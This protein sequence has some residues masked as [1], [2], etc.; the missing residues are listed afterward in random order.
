VVPFANNDNPTRGDR[1]DSCWLREARGRASAI[2]KRATATACDRS[3]DSHG[4]DV[5]DAMIVEVGHD[6]LATGRDHGDS[7]RVLEARSCACTVGKRV[8]ATARKRC[9]NTKWRQEPDAVVAE[10]SHDDIVARGDHRNSDRGPE[11]CGRAC[12]VSKRSASAARKRCDDAEGCH[13]PDAMILR[14]GHNDHAARGDHGDSYRLVEACG[15]ARAVGITAIA[16][17][18]RCDDAQ[19]RNEPDAVVKGVGNDNHAA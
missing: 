1:N 6:N 3:D 4:R 10:V 7:V 15:R 2:G 14:V 16:A 17:C 18:K 13:E 11:A 19:E 12:T 9:D 5:P 8:V